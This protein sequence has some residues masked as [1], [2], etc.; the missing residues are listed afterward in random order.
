MASAAAS[1]VGSEELF[2]IVDPDS[3]D[4][5][6]VASQWNLPCPILQIRK[7]NNARLWRKYSVR[8]VEP[9]PYQMLLIGRL[10]TKLLGLSN[11]HGPISKGLISGHRT[12]KPSLKG[13]LI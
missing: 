3:K 2:Q 8:T 4:Y 9:G 12:Y 1:V 10:I 11:D 13:D 5:H 6:D 7:V